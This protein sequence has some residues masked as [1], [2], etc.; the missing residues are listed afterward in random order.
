L[1]PVSEVVQKWKTRIKKPE[2][3]KEP[4]QKGRNLKLKFNCDTASCG[5]GFMMS[6]TARAKKKIGNWGNDKARTD[7][8]SH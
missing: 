3:K 1:K 7:T 5:L 2:R 4:G 6:P 8:D